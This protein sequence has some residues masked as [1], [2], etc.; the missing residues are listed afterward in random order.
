MTKKTYIIIAV[1]YF[2]FQIVVVI[3]GRALAEYSW[4]ETLI[5]IVFV[6]S[7]A[8]AGYGVMLI[9]RAHQAREKIWS[10]VIATLLSGFWGILG[11]ILTVVSLFTK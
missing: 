10:L 5:R 2:F 9:A 4:G 3:G 6:G 11:A 8:Y 1:V 7:L